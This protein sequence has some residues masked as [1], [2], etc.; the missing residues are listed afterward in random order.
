MK[1]LMLLLII[2][3]F[4]AAGQAFAAPALDQ[5]SPNTG[6]QFNAD[7]SG[8]NWQQQVTVGVTGKLVEVDLYRVPWGSNNGG[9]G[10]DT[11]QIDFYLN[12]GSGWQTDANNYEAVITLVTQSA[13]NAID[14]SS[15]NLF[16]TAGEQFVIG[17]HGT[18][19]GT[20]LGG[21]ANNSADPYSGGPLY[22][23][24]TAYDSIASNGF[25]YSIGFNTWVDPDAVPPPPP[26]TAPEPTTM[27]LLGLG[28]VGL[29]GVRRKFQN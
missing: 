14:V 4:V 26:T 11:G 12:V 3:S 10:P 20:G 6:T 27:L 15:A 7:I 8:F 5:T 19:E 21:S 24:G 28:L 9:T 29:A 25:Y 13:L 17:W 16:V 22:F 2:V 1:K 18:N 23:N